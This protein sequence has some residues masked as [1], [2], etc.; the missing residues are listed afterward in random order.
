MKLLFII[1]YILFVNISFGQEFNRTYTSLVDYKNS[2]IFQKYDL[3]F[4]NDENF[5]FSRY[6][7]EECYTYSETIQGKWKRSESEIHFYDIDQNNYISK[8]KENFKLN[9]I[10]VQENCVRFYESK[11]NNDIYLI[12]LND[13]FEIIEILQSTEYNYNEKEFLLNTS[14]VIPENSFQLIYA[15]G[16]L[17]QKVKEKQMYFDGGI[18]L[19]DFK[20][21]NSFEIS[22]C[23]NNSDDNVKQIINSYFSLEIQKDGSMI[24]KK[25]FIELDGKPRKRVFKLENKKK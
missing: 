16:R 18:S 25:D 11:D 21:F 7:D 17:N 3:I 22:N 5:E 23:S 15:R 8:N 2:S 14:F 10:N 19:V 24:S 20:D 13:Q 4:L 12:A 6:A 1:S 9:Q